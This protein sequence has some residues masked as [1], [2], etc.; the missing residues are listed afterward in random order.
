M[1][2][3]KTKKLYILGIFLVPRNKRTVLLSLIF[4]RGVI[5]VYK[6]RHG[7]DAFSSIPEE[8]KQFHLQVILKSTL[9]K[10][11]FALIIKQ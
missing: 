4:T 3:S 8:I 6:Y 10:I 7:R 9:L 1:C 11:L 5:F 2:L